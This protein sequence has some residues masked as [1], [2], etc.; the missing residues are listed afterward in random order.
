MSAKARAA[1]LLTIIW[2]VALAGQAHG[3]SPNFLLQIPE[4]QTAP[5]QGAGEL[6]HPRGIVADPDSGHVFVAEYNN[7]RISEYT[8][9]G[10]FVKSWGWG[11]AT[12]APTLQS[13]GPPQPQGSPDPSL[14]QAG[15]PGPGK[16]QLDLP[17]GMAVDPAGNV[18]VFETGNLRVQKFS[19]SGQ[20]LV[21]FGGGVNVTKVGEGAPAA[22]QNVC[23]IDPDDLC[24]AGSAGEEPSQLAGSISDQIAYS[25]ADGGTILVG[26]TDGIQVF[27]LNGNYIRKIPFEGPLGAFA[28]QTVN[29]LDVDKDGSVYFSTSGLEDVFKA[30]PSGEPLGPGKPEASKFEVGN[31]L[32][33]A[34]DVNGNVY[35]IDDPPGISPALEARVVMFD[36]TGT[37][38]VPTKGEEEAGQFFPY[39]P[40]LGPLINGLATN[41]CEG[42]EEP[43]SLYVTF[44]TQIFDPPRSYVD[45]YGTSPIGCELPPK[46]PPEVTAQ[47][48][49]SVGREEATVK[50]QINPL[51]WPDTTYYVEYG[52]SRC[53]EGGCPLHVPVPAALLTSKSVNAPLAT[54]GAVLGGLRPNATYHYRFV[55]QSTGGGPVYGVD[56]DGRG[57]PAQATFAAG[58]EATFRTF[59]PSGIRGGCPNDALRLGPMD[60]LPDCRGYEMVSPLDKGSGDVAL[61]RGRNALYPEFFEL[62]QTASS[63]DRFTYTSAF[64]FAEP[65][66]A[67]YVS[68]YLAERGVTGWSSR[69]LA[70]PHAETPVPA[71]VL[72]GNEFHGFSADLCQGWAL[73]YSTAPLATGAIPGYP[74]LYRRDNC[75]APP[76]YEALTIKKPPNR[77]AA[78]YVQVRIQGFSDNGTH[79]IFTANGALHPD[80][81]TLTADEREL[82]LY[83]HVN[84]ELRFVCY[85]PSGNPSPDRCSAGTAAGGDGA[86]ASPL[87]NAISSDGS[88]IFWSAYDGLP[89]FGNDAGAP[90]Q[91]YVRIDGQETRKVS[92]TKS[93]DPAWY[94]TASDDGSKAVFE[95]AAGS[96]KDQ[97]Y[98]LNVDTQKPTLIAKEVEGPMGVSEDASRIYFASKGD[99]DAEGPALA[100]DHNLYLYETNAAG[101]SGSFSFVMELSGQDILGTADE[102]APIDEL[103]WQRSA[104][105]SPDGLHVAFTSIASPTPT[106]YDNRDA[107]SG[108]AAQE[109]YLYDAVEKRLRCVSCNQTGARPI[110][111]ELDGPNV[112]YAAARLQGW[113]LLLHAPR[114]LSDD[115]T[116]VFF[117]S[118]EALV[119]RDTNGTWDVYQWEEA[120]KGTCNAA[121]ETFSDASGGCV[122]LI[123]AGTSSAKSTFLDADPSGDNAFF[124][125]Q[126]SLVGADYGLNDVYVARVGGGFPEPLVRAPCQ[127]EACQSPRPPPSEV[128]PSTETSSGPGNVKR[129]P[130]RCRKGKRRVRRAGKVRC[131]KRKANAGR[132]AGARRRAGR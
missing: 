26:D 84:G 86:S 10:L 32:G 66:A 129:K 18:Y 111:Q 16:G 12:G 8:A 59:R 15:S 63:G 56:P 29:A 112:F 65:Q 109:V 5:G 98:E 81:P 106:G 28:G 42:S 82:L 121:S 127:G 7:A 25:P 115:G 128:T 87:H 3:A 38:L 124:S 125:T 68:Q 102:R 4:R 58:L 101:G 122:D 75:A 64:A 83:E 41:I 97:L 88:R 79:T 33:V 76:V 2:A 114:V 67:P 30:G 85:L 57:G 99:L 118:F 95:F 119:P 113:E 45:A 71:T 104:R 46:R 131:V 72:F 96:L 1:V 132:R 40:T 22:Q 130:R 74:N 103:P 27:D 73:L 61:W 55:A 6:D 116:R 44:F 69:S 20:F 9:W 108:E 34:V 126:T 91:I 123:S 11:V 36:A 43:G 37:R 53:R 117:E 107:N 50:A 100:G 70:L 60:A 52:P 78:K 94:W 110:G 93:S 90:G 62:H 31:P 35:A 49:S 24:G 92:T 17:V 105:V 54:A 23:P 39:V 120:G 51:F 19:P 14:C 77:K 80:A 48:A 89:G 21:M 47:F 13:C